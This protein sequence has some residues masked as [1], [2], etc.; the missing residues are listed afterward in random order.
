LISP[1][2][3]RIRLAPRL[4]LA[5]ASIALLATPAGAQQTPLRVIQTVVL[6]PGHGG[7]NDGA[8]GRSG[9]LEKD[10]TLLVAHAIRDRLVADHPG[11]NVVIT[12]HLDVDIDLPD[13][14]HAAH[15]VEADLFLSLHMNSARNK[16][17]QGFEV[18]YLEPDKAMPLTSEDPEGWG[19]QFLTT[20]SQADPI[21][22]AGPEG[23]PLLLADLQLA[24]AHLDSAMLA[25]VLLQELKRACPGHHSRGV[26]QANFGVLRGARVPAVVV[27]F[28]FLSHASE[29][30]WLV[31]P[32][33]RMRFAAAASQTVARMDQF[34]YRRDVLP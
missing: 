23:L 4:A 29:E 10:E 32:R 19:D 5:L 12:R 34:L 21:H 25:S 7:G 13:R 31:R 26:R 28:G 20:H 1:Q 22:D 30:R 8:V 24:R 16:K 33:T 15:E 6:D 14:I 27:E 11:L 17:A 3:I 9:T 18:F 2:T